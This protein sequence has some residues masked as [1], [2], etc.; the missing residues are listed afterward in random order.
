MIWGVRSR[1]YDSAA[2]AALFYEA[3][4]LTPVNG[5]AVTGL[6]G[7]SGGDVVKISSP[8]AATWVSMLS[9]TIAATTGNFT[10]QGRYR[11]WARCYSSTGTPQFQFLWG[12]GSLSVPVTN[13]PVTLPGSSAFYLLDLGEVRFDGPPVGRQ[14]VVRGCAGVFAPA[15]PTRRRSTASTSSRSTKR[16]AC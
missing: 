8:P 6:S 1:Y 14:R 15:A 2:T 7:A 11:V 5:A 12:V 3:E 10:H 13:D 4:A 16:Q 9:T